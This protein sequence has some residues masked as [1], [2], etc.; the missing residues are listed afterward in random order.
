MLKIADF[1]LSKIGSQFRTYVGTLHYIAPEV[2][3]IGIVE[4]LTKQNYTLSA[5]MWS[6]GCILFRYT[7]LLMHNFF[8]TQLQVS[9]IE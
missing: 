5:D 3:K 1:G 9:Y 4:Q 7:Q 8:C 2:L 6:L